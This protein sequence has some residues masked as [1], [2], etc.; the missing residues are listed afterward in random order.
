[1]PS[2]AERDG[3]V[4]IAYAREDQAFALLLLADLEVRGVRVWMDHKISPGSR[5]DES[6]QAALDRATAMIVVLSEQS[7]ASPHVADEVAYALDRKIPV[8]PVLREACEV[9]LRM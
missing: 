5:W 8:I 3:P 2:G 6:V 1:M 4:F 7:V 9:P